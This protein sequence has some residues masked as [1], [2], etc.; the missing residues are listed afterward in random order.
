M[1]PNGVKQRS[2][3]TVEFT[4]LIVVEQQDMLSSLGYIVLHCS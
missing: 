2:K 3:Y 1:L 4:M